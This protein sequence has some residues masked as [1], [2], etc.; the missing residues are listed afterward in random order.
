[1]TNEKKKILSLVYNT[2]KNDTRVLKTCSSLVQRGYDVE[3][4]AAYDSSLPEYEIVNGFRVKR[5]FKKP[6]NKFFTKKK[7]ARVLKKSRRFIFKIPILVLKSSPQSYSVAKYLTNTFERII[8]RAFKRIY[9]SC[10]FFFPVSTRSAYENFPFDIIH[11]NDLLPLPL[12]VEI[13]RENPNIK[14]VYDTHE[15]QTELA[16]LKNQPERK[17]HFEILEK[18]NISQVSS[19][20][21]VSPSIATEYEKL[22][23]L[24]KVNVVRNCPD[25]FTEVFEG[26]YFSKYFN[27]ADDKIIFLY[28]GGFTRGKGI[29]DTLYAF[30]KIR[31]LGITTH[32]IIFMGMGGLENEIKEM[33]ARHDNIHYHPMIKSDQLPEISS[34]ADY[35][36]FFAPN[37]SKNHWFCLPNKIFE[38]VT[39]GLPVIVSPLFEVEKLVNGEKLGFV[40]NDFSPDALFELIK[41]INHKPTNEMRNYIREIHRTK[42][43]WQIEEKTLYEVYDN[44]SR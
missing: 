23:G 20:V 34:S 29:E 40:A 8:K 3:V 28:Q 24:N 30:A 25:L 10:R 2:F 7:F 13:K 22:Y 44:L 6:N 1:M 37:A 26:K 27:L 11:C 32:H 15:F 9:A 12:A 19:V 33:A 43:N 14:I 4:W 31:E 18:N 36:I 41:G 35:G 38:Y 17:K 16:G 21:T 5:K 42:L 39:S